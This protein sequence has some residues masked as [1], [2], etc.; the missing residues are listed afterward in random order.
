MF[1]FFHSLYG[2][3]PAIIINNLYHKEAPDDA[4]SQNTRFTETTQTS[5]NHSVKPKTKV[6]KLEDGIV[7]L[8]NNTFFCYM[9]ACLQCF[10]AIEP[11]R[12]YFMARHYTSV[13]ST[14]KSGK[15]FCSKFDEFYSICYSKS[16]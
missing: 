12:D 1:Y 2:G 16:S 10:L 9:N 7:G 15:D 5:Y 14:R 13:K 11:L 6:P 3:G 4:I 8:H